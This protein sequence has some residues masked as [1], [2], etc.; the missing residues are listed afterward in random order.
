LG[1]VVTIC[2]LDL[3][4]PYALVFGMRWKS[5]Q[6]Y[7]DG[8]PLQFKGNGKGLF[9]SWLIWW[10]LTAVSLEFIAFGS[11]PKYKCGSGNALFLRHGKKARAHSFLR[12]G[13]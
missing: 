1:A 3:A 9:G 8:K 11:A 4:Y 5:Q 6:A 12:Y 2:A 7:K 10:L 13:F